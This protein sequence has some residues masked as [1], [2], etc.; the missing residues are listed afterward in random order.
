[1][2]FSRG[3]I[4]VPGMPRLEAYVGEVADR[5]RDV[6]G[7]RLVGVW[8]L[9]SAALGDYDPRRSDVDVQAVA[10]GRLSLSERADLAARL[11]H[12]ALANPARGLEFVLY[13]EDDLADDGGPRFQ[14]NLNTGPRMEHHAVYD[15]DEDPRFWFTIDVSVARQ[16]G[17]AFIGPPAA[18][19]FPEPPRNL[20]V[21]AVLEALDFYADAHDGGNGALLS[22]CRA[23]AWAVDGVWRSKAD[24]VRWA[25]RQLA[26]PGP[27]E[28]ALRRRNGE[29]VAAPTECDVQRMLA[30][31][32]TAL[33]A[34]AYSD[35]APR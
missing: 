30:T 32:R 35:A 17:V 27:V 31:A 25:M 14:L 26:D 12:E 2:P 33:A 34:V 22:A 15:A 10:T 16:C 20:M 18:T 28:S 1:M 4:L 21:T 6:V 8:L 9:G 5:V 13:A 11:G 23:W 29:P 7:E 24:S 3:S 19:V